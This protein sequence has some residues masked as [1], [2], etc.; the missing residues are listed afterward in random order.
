M[1]ALP[2]T[3]L[4]DFGRAFARPFFS[5]QA[6]PPLLQQQRIGWVRSH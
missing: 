2:H 3:S 5:M 4:L 6:L 1:L